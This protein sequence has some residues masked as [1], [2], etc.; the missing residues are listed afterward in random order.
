VKQ[1]A[2][3]FAIVALVGC[4]GGSPS[5]P[6]PPV[7]PPPPAPVNRAPTL[8]SMNFAPTF[9]MAGMTTFSF[10]AAATD[11]DG[12]SLSFTWSVA[13]N[14][15][16]GTAGTI[17]FAASN[18]GGIPSA[19]VTVTDGKG[20]SATDRR[21]FVLGS[22]TGSWLITSGPLTGSTFE[23]T[24]TETGLTTGSFTLPGLGTG[25]TDP[26]QPGRITEAGALTM[27]V[28]IGRFT[29]FNMNG[30]MSTSTGRSVSGS[31][32]GSGFTGQPF[33]MEATGQPV[34]FAAQ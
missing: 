21:L 33:T 7:T 13:G 31:L 22:M 14:P 4:G 12:D 10:N 23:L 8:T 19:S 26:A 2:V 5:S 11:L 27:R 17:I 20:G 34:T 1:T 28:K 15:L 16:T 18:T 3:L 29:D 6:T 9:G 32:Q 30:N 24:Q 25:N